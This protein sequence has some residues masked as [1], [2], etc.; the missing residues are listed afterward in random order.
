MNS[1]SRFFIRTFAFLGKEIFEILRQPQLI[2]TLILGPFLILL[3]FGIGYRNEARPLRTLF[4][5]PEDSALREAV[6]QQVTQMGPQL[7]F[8]GITSSEEEARRRLRENEVDVV[9]VVPA[10][11]VGKIRNS[12]QVQ[13]TLLHNEI[14]P[15][16][17]DYIRVFGRVYADEVNRRV[18]QSI[19]QEGQ[20]DASSL[21]QAIGSARTNASAA[22]E[23]LE[24]GDQAL[25]GVR[26]G[27]LRRDVS[28]IDL[29]VGGSV[30]LLGG[31][32]RMAG[33]SSSSG[34]EI[35][36]LLTDV[37]QDS[38]ALAN[39][40]V[41]T[42]SD[43]V[44]R[45]RELEEELALLEAELVE[46]QQIDPNVLVSPFRSETQSIA[47]LQLR[48]V[49][50]YA[51]AV[52][53]LLLQ[54]FALT[55]AALSIVRERRAGTM[56]LFR[57]A[58]ISAIETLIGKYS[59][60]LLFIVIIAA[61]L[62]A[63]IVFGLGVPILGDWVTFALVLLALIFTALGMGFVLSLVAETTSQAVQYSMILLLAS[64]FFTGFFLS[65]EMLWAPVRIVSW[66]LPATYGIQLLQNVMLRGI[67]GDWT[68]LINL[69]AI[70]LNFFFIS[71][72]LLSWRMSRQ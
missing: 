36:G 10:D 30:A 13:L 17:S 46:F 58:P 41:R 11:P 4:V 56:E 14:D 63:L 53:I 39:E 68:L 28:Q 40:D 6:E 38:E 65:I 44:Q 51:P 25:A 61:I 52:I 23:A 24:R 9:A 57:V 42:G 64:V 22:R 1:L 48:I 7:L 43:A 3:L 55:F 47:P 71:W 70:G 62:T 20:R 21:E 67:V 32:Q 59:S 45:A 8:A 31:V 18:L 27:D 49:D 5:V 12:E 54:H 16:E 33:T 15:L 69:A 37:R 72:L 29:L 66:M 34:N 2:L 26:A 50:Y 60:Y 35:S 19:T